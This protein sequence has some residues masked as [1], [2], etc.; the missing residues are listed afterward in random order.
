MHKRL[1]LAL[2]VVFAL[3]AGACGGDDDKKGDDA[4]PTTTE[5]AGGSGGEGEGW[6]VLVYSMADNNLEGDLMTDIAEMAAVGSGEGLNIIDLADRAVGQSE[7]ELLDI[8]SWEGGKLLHV[9]QGS[10]E[11][12]EDMGDID[13]GDPKTLSDFI[14][15]GIGEYPAAH[16]SVIISDHGGAWTG[17]GTDESTGNAMDL[18]ELQTAISTGL[19]DAGVDKLDLLGFDAC[20]MSTYEVASVMAPFADRLIASSET[21]PGTGWNYNVLQMLL[22]DPG[23]SVDDLGTAIV[24][25]Y[26]AQVEETNPNSGITLALL[27]LT[28]MSAMDDAMTAF[29]S[30]L[31]ERTANV[32]PVIGRTLA[33]AQSYGKNDDPSLAQN[34]VDLGAMAAQ[35]GVDALDVS[36]EAD[37]VQQ[38]LNDMVLHKIQGPQA[39][40][41]SGLA[42]Y[43]PPQQELSSAEYANIP[44]NPSGW[45]DFL[46]A[47]YTVGDAIPE[48]EQA[49][50]ASDEA[51]VTFDEDGLVIEGTFEI[52]AQDNLSEAVIRY[53]FVGEDGSI[54]LIG[55]EP[56]VISD[57][58]SGLAQ[59]SYDLTVLTISDGEDT[60][61]AYLALQEADDE[62]AGGFIVNVPLDYYAPDQLDEGGVPQDAVLTLTADADGNII[63]ETYFLYEEGGTVGELNAEEG[64]VI[65]PKTLVIDADGNET[66]T[67]TTD[68][69]LFADL[70]SL[71]YDLAPLES[72]TQLYVQLSVTD[73]GGNTDNVSTVVT[74][75]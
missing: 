42:I 48:E 31:A 15:R 46:V 9:N 51:V 72:G 16:Y 45:L 69:G 7:D 36:D 73:F 8:G 75:P 60:T 2:L 32:A 33:T 68:I 29:S 56:G 17:M 10:V 18:T 65:V 67:G 26:Q 27:D 66:W 11:V 22:D 39:P 3:V 20:L 25:G 58:G 71:Q 23:T 64:A 38:A 43:F 52:A 1:G 37:A 57:D 49:S 35:I 30:T 4:S 61:Y 40:D 53:G 5:D 59:A 6:T 70:P 21:E 13:T 41:F 44:E 62:G 24:D 12:L 55:R 14:T 19:S 34:S 47:Y 74:V 63:D 50:F 54:E 28:Q